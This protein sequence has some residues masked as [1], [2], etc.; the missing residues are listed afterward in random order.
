M[1][2]SGA[3]LKVSYGFFE[4]YGLADGRGHV[5]HNSKKYGKVVRVSEAVFADGRQILVSDLYGQDSLTV[6]SRA[7]S[8]LGLPYDLFNANCEHF[9]RHCLGLDVESPQVQKYL[10]MLGCSTFA[11]RSNNVIIKAGAYSALLAAILSQEDQSVNDNAVAACL[12]T[13]GV[14][15]LCS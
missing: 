3:C 11:A 14:G 9:V 8:C 4:H 13:L 7:L 15:I 2:S 10:L 5:I 12:L 6:G 1:Y